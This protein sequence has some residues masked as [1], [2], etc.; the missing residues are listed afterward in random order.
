MPAMKKSSKTKKSKG[1]SM[2]SKMYAGAT[3]K[4]APKKRK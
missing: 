3:K 2:K 4:A 1:M